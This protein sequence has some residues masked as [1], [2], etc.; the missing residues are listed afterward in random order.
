MRLYTAILLLLA[1]CSSFAQV[2]FNGGVNVATQF[3]TKVSVHATGD[4]LNASSTEFENSNMQIILAGSDQQVQGTFD[5]SRL[6]LMGSGE[7]LLT[8]YLHVRDELAFT[9]GILKISASGKLLF[10]GYAENITANDNS[11][12]LGPLYQRGGGVRFYP[13]GTES[14][15]APVIFTSVQE[16]EDEIGVLAIDGAPP[17][18]ANNPKINRVLTKNHWQIIAT[19]ISTLGSSVK[20]PRPDPAELNTDEQAIVIEDRSGIAHSLGAVFSDEFVVSAD[21]VTSNIVALATTTELSLTI[22]QLLTPFGSSGENDDL[23]IVN[24]QA[25]DHNKV[26]LFDRYGVLLKTWT[27][28]TNGSN[29]E[30]FKTLSPGHYIVVVEYGTDESEVMTKSGMITVLRGK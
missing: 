30:F 9:E 25:F 6:E 18:T 5:I 7:K 24:L 12:V 20:L 23:H 26:M 16:Q 14:G 3:G 19:D 22:K 21:V 10:S 15:Y 28:Y 8:G 2:V 4:L 17:I 1:P 29:P 11:F 13:I 27:N